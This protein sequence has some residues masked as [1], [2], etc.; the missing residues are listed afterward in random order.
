MDKEFVTAFADII[1][2]QIV[3]KNVITIKGLGTF[4]QIHRKQYQK[5]HSNGQVVMMPPKDEIEFIPDK[6]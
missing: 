5:Q 3:R 6:S 1:R 4:K 2:D